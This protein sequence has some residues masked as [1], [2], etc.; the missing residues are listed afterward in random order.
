MLEP[1]GAERWKIKRH[2]DSPFGT[3][4]RPEHRRLENGGVSK[5]P[6]MLPALISRTSPHRGESRQRRG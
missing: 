2:P 3:R 1:V 6:A 5:R 4:P